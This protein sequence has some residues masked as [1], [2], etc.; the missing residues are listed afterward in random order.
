MGDC[1]KRGVSFTFRFLLTVKSWIE[2]QLDMVR[3]A[4]LS[5]RETAY[6]TWLQNEVMENDHAQWM[7]K[8]WLQIGCDG[9]N[10]LHEYCANLSHVLLQ[11]SLALT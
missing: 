7:R 9:K 1:L 4:G 8:L 5:D 6:I 11:R 10:N 3:K 2:S